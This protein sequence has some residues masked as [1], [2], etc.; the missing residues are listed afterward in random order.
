MHKRGETGWARWAEEEPDEGKRGGGPIVSS[1]IFSVDLAGRFG[2]Q[3]GRLDW[4]NWQIRRQRLGDNQGMLLSFSLFS[5][6]SSGPRPD[7]G[8]GTGCLGPW[9]SSR[10][11]PVPRSSLAAYWSAW[12]RGR[13]EKPRK[14]KE[15]GAAMGPTNLDVT[16]DAAHL[17]AHFTHLDGWAPGAG[18]WALGTGKEQNWRELAES[19][20]FHWH[21]V[22]FLG[23]WG[24][25][26]AR[27][28]LRLIF[29]GH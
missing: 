8:M 13:E 5:V 28:G 19:R 25:A 4:Q 7:K 1:V 15:P 20:A 26:L 10:R 2:W 22:P 23:D 12:E 3:D 24:S 9:N 14:G 29:A 6:F 27:L 11:W 18:H 17:S 21:W 16:A